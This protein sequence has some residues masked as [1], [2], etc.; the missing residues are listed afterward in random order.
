MDPLD[1]APPLPDAYARAN[2]RRTLRRQ[3]ALLALALAV[4]VVPNALKFAASLAEF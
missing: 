4:V 3:V 2:L 1:E